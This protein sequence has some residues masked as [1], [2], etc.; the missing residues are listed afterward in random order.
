[1]WWLQLIKNKAQ[2]MVQAYSFANILNVT[3]RAIDSL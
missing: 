2:T 1:M 3:C